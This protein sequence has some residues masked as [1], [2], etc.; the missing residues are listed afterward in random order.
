MPLSRNTVDVVTAT[1]ETFKLTGIP[2]RMVFWICRNAHEIG[3]HPKGRL[4][5]FFADSVVRPELTNCFDVI[6][7]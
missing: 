2:A 4:L 5:F 6:E 7:P 1:G 3:R